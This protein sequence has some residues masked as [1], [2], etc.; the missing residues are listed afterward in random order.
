MTKYRHKVDGNQSEIVKALRNAGAFVHLQ[1]ADKGLFDMIVGYDG[2]WYVL[3]VKDPD[4]SRGNKLT[5]DEIKYI[6]DIRNRAKVYPVQSA[7]QAL[8]I[9]G[10]SKTMLENK[11][12]HEELAATIKPYLTAMNEAEMKMAKIRIQALINQDP[13]ETW[14]WRNYSTL[15]AGGEPKRGDMVKIGPEKVAVKARQAKQN[16]PG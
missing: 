6:C 10:A 3:E 5:M 8:A 15:S 16:K 9:I 12:L 1:P 11:Y 4:S 14:T 13:D 7:E 2:L